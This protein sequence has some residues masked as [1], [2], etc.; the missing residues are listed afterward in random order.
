MRVLISVISLL[1][2]SDIQ[3][4]YQE[5]YVDFAVDSTNIQ[6]FGHGIALELTLHAAGHEK[7][8]RKD[9]IVILKQAQNQ[10]EEH[11]KYCL[12]QG[13]KYD[14][15]SLRLICYNPANPSSI[16]ENPLYLTERATFRV[17]IKAL[18]LAHVAL[19]LQAGRALEIELTWEI[20]TPP[21]YNEAAQD[22]V[23]ASQNPCLNYDYTLFSLFKY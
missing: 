16:G 23:L 22:W 18:S 21:I 10:E 1:L 12:P 19:F 14:K 5:S 13:T 2:S 6:H 15:F 17:P 20:F 7:D 4:T 9:T 8:D 11:A 3:A